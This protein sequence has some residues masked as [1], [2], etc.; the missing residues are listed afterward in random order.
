MKRSMVMTIAFLCAMPASAQGISGTTSPALD[1]RPGHGHFN[2]GYWTG[3]GTS[4]FVRGPII[5][6]RPAKD[7][8]DGAAQD[9]RQ[10]LTPQ[11]E[12][13]LHPQVGKGPGAAGEF[14][15]VVNRLQNLVDGVA[16]VDQGIARAQAR[17]SAAHAKGKLGPA[18]ERRI[19]RRLRELEA[20]R[21][22]LIADLL[23]RGKVGCDVRAE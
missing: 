23:A 1:M 9:A 19:A 20:E 5:L 15:R 7:S 21:A 18:L 4:S 8:A 17:L 12:A 3:P 10:S 2:P 11:W 13:V 22:A 6:T 16:R 14:R